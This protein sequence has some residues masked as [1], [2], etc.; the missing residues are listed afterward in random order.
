MDPFLSQVKQ[1]SATWFQVALK[2]ASFFSL[3]YKTALSV[4][5]SVYV[6]GHFQLN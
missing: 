5:F 4:L 1:Q 6:L 3:Y 2:K